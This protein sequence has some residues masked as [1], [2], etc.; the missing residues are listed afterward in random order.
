MKE[1]LRTVLGPQGGRLLIIDPR[2]ADFIYLGKCFET[3]AVCSS[4]NRTNKCYERLR[5]QQVLSPPATLLCALIRHLPLQGSAFDALLCSSGLLSTDDIHP[6]KLLK[7]LRG[8]VRP[9][10]TLLVVSNVAEGIM[11]SMASWARKNLIRRA[12]LPLLTE[13]TAWML[14]AG[15]RSVRQVSLTRKMLPQVVTWAEVRHRPWDKDNC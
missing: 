4:V 12:R 2:P 15:L 13:L 11:G 6:I 8:L 9:G 5:L 14:H 3:V 7:S 10:G 1:V